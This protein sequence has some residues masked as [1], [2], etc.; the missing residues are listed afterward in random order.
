MN[1]LKN[2]LSKT[3]FYHGIHHVLDVKEAVQV[4][5]QKENLTGDESLD[6]L[7]TAALYHDCG[8]LDTYQDHEEAGCSIARKVLPDFDFTPEQIETICGMIMATKIP[9]NPK[10]HLEEILCDAD[11]DYLGRDDFEPIAQ[12]LFVE[13]KARNIVSDIAV[14]NSIQVKF[15]KSHHYWTKS[16]RESRETMKQKRLEELIKGEN[17]N[18]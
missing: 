12:T 16:A 15:L 13:L 2:E 6:L 8:F 1:L 11:L 18:G 5:A 3:L 14:W 9:Q 10:T 17:V 4:L 7:K